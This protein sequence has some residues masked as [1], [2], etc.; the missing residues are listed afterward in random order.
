VRIAIVASHPVQYNSPLFRALAQRIHLT[1]FYGHRATTADQAHAGFGTEFEWDVDLLSG[2]AYEFL[3]NRSS[4]P[5]LGH[6]G[7]VDTPD[8]GAR[9]RTGNFDA[10]VL[11]GWFLKCYLQALASARK[12]RIPVLVRGDSHLNTPRSAWKR[13]AKELA[14]P[15]FL[16]FFDGALAVGMRNREY[17]RHYHFPENRIFNAPHCVDNDWF[18]S[19]ATE[20]A[21]ACV[22]EKLG[23]AKDAKVVLFAGKLVP[24]K[25]PLDVIAMTKMLMQQGFDLEVLVA[26]SGPLANE[27]IEAA[28]ASGVRLHMMG[29]CNQSEMP[30]AYAAS[31]VLVL[32]SDG[33]ESWGLVANEALACGRPVV[34][35]DAVGCAPDMAAHLGNRIVFQSGDVDSMANCVKQVLTDPVDQKLVSSVAGRFS[36]QA[37][38]DGIVNAVA[39][40]THSQ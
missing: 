21:R 23:I 3:P 11:M 7:G 6:F 19:R 18:A 28:H 9:L 5:E 34:L 10:I 33:R 22:R 39:T 25:R 16:R 2:Y 35:S 24:F 31:D 1:V 38:S 14:Y 40:V 36:L 27:M 30:G 20:S 32:P 13:I 4:R 37:A 29:F 26:G 8:I 15:N 12:Y 17:W